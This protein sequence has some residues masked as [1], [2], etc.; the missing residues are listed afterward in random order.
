MWAKL[1]LRSAPMMPD[2]A[3]LSDVVRV[4]GFRYCTDAESRKPPIIVTN[5]SVRVMIAM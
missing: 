2:R 5:Q 1:G 3:S 4:S